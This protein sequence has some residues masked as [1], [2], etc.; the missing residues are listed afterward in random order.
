MPPRRGS[1][2]FVQHRQSRELRACVSLGVRPCQEDDQD[3]AGGATP[4]IKIVRTNG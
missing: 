1:F 2:S 4:C 3:E